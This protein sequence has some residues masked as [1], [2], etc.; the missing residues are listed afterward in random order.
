MSYPS[1]LSAAQLCT[2]LS[3]WAGMSPWDD[4]P[5]G[6][7]R[8]RRNTVRSLVAYGLVRRDDDGQ[9]RLTDLGRG[10]VQRE[11]PRWMC[12]RLAAPART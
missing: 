8:A 5:E 9:W 12:E 2:L 3:L 6:M 11:A 1:K 4:L 7:R 10:C